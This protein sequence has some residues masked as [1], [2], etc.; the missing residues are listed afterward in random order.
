MRCLALTVHPVQAN[1][2]FFRCGLNATPRPGFTGE[3]CLIIY[4]NWSLSECTNTKTNRSIKN[5][6][7]LSEAALDVFMLCKLNT[8]SIAFALHLIGK[9]HL[10]KDFAI[11]N[12]FVK[13]WNIHSRIRVEVPK[14]VS[15]RQKCSSRGFNNLH[16]SIA[17]RCM[18]RV[19]KLKP[20]CLCNWRAAFSARMVLRFNEGEFLRKILWSNGNLGLAETDHWARNKLCT[21]TNL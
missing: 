9:G 3:T 7:D 21:M 12:I 8:C 6:C 10:E 18:K 4:P 14:A 20:G 11:I 13:G 17:C 16:V 2:F 19:I 15:Y 5:I 1:Q